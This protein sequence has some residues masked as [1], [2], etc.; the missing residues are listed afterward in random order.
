MEQ[1]HNQ[2]VE[3][4]KNDVKEILEGYSMDNQ[5]YAK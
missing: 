1:Q 4:I 3:K 2:E 5:E